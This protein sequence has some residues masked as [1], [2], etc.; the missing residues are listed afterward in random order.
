MT[1]D[2]PGAVKVGLLVGTSVV[3]FVPVDARADFVLICNYTGKEV[4][5]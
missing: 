4:V 2:L 1:C 3:T 5:E